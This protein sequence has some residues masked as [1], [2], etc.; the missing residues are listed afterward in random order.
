M[1]LIY[2]R[3]RRPTSCSTDRTYNGPLLK[4]VETHFDEKEAE[5]LGERTTDDPVFVGFLDTIIAITRRHITGLVAHEESVHVS[6]LVS[7]GVIPVLLKGIAHYSIQ[8]RQ[9]TLM[10]IFQDIMISDP[11]HSNLFFSSSPYNGLTVLHQYIQ[12]QRCNNPLVD[13]G[14]LPAA[15]C[16]LS[17]VSQIIDSGYVASITED[18][19]SIDH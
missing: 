16:T 18:T 9:A 15:E 6:A 4:V 11:N 1:Y 14:G 17:L 5:S 10:S 19:C 13:D 3:V 7:A 2:G 12:M 8:S